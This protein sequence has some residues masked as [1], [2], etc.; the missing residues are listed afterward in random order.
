MPTFNGTLKNTKIQRTNDTYLSNAQKGLVFGDIDQL[1]NVVS[2]THAG[3]EAVNDN[4]DNQ[5][6]TGQLRYPE[7]D[8]VVICFTPGT[9]LAT[10]RGEVAVENLR[11][12]DRVITRDNGIKTLAWAGK[13]DFTGPEL[14]SRPE[15]NPVHIS[16]GALGNDM[17][18]RDMVVSPNHRMVITS[19]IADVLFGEREVLV[20]AKHLTSLDGVDQVATPAVQYIHLMFEQHEI[21]LANGAWTESFLPGD[22]S[23][24]GIG[25]AQRCE[26]VALFPELETTVGMDNYGP[27]RRS[28]KMQ[29][30]ANLTCR[31]A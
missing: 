28:L 3:N 20:A 17:P 15:F 30:A 24:N 6:S 8:Q 19:S 2:L 26:I 16:K 4:L 14:A 10:V 29:E 25:V 11:E 12:G 31:L 13:R 9:C 21:V 23:L 1:N 5:T 27:A 22:R 7:N 18:K